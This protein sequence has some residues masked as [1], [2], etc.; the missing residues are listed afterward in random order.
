M[1]KQFEKNDT[2]YISSDWNRF[3][4]ATVQ[5]FT[6]ESWGKQ[7]A[8][9]RLTDGTMLKQRVY[10]TN[11]QNSSAFATREEATTHAQA[12]LDSKIDARLAHAK[13]SIEHMHKYNQYN[14][15]R[16]MKETKEMRDFEENGTYVLDYAEAVRRLFAE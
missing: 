9:L 5:K 10:L 1:T 8:T 7:Q 11:G 2:I 14:T 12:H 16:E 6:V 15:R 13:E 3:H 4:I